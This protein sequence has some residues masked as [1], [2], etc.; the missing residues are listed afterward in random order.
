MAEKTSMAIWKEHIEDL[1]ERPISN[2]ELIFDTGKMKLIVDDVDIFHQMAE[3]SG[4][5]PMTEHSAVPWYLLKIPNEKM[6]DRVLRWC[7]L[8]PENLAGQYRSKYS[9]CVV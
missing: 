7:V 8:L 6:N 3:K 2:D 9:E 4:L 1:L 5:R